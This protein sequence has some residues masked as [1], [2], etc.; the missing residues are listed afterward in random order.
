MFGKAGNCSILLQTAP[1]MSVLEIVAEKHLG[2]NTLKKHPQLRAALRRI[3]GAATQATEKERIASIVEL[4]F[5]YDRETDAEEKANILRLLE[6]IS[7]NEPI[8]LPKESVEQWEARLKEE[9]PAYARAEAPAKKKT[10]AF[11]KKY[12]AL[13]ARAKLATQADVA[14]KSGLARSYVAVIESGEHVPQQKTLQKLSK[15][16][17]VDV[18]DLMP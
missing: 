18:A 12:F 13:R 14:R 17:G 6:E 5:E 16:F 10:A 2:M 8:E 4:C 3:E 9:N 1:E 11:L 7:G 15:A